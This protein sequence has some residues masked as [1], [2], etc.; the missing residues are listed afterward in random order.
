[1]N[2]NSS[3]NAESSQIQFYSEFDVDHIQA[4]T[5]VLLAFFQQKKVKNQID[6]STNDSK[7]NMRSDEIRFSIVIE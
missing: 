5:T 1:M 7:K 2:A 3:T 4:M 6:I